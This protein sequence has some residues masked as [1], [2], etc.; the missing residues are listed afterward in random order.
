[1]RAVKRNQ[2]KMHCCFGAKEKPMVTQVFKFMILQVINCSCAFICVVHFS[3]SL[4]FSHD[5]H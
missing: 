2:P 1:M 3:I 5:L 4:S